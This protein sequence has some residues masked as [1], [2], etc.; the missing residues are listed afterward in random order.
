MKLY[1]N[2]R[3]VI[4]FPRF[5][6]RISSGQQGTVYEYMGKALKILHNDCSLFD[7]DIS[8]KDYEHLKKIDTKR[9]LLPEDSLIDREDNLRAYTLELITKNDY[10]ELFNI[11]KDKFIEELY[12]VR[13]ELKLLSENNVIVH[14]LIME[15]FM[16]DGI[17]RFVDCGR[18]DIEYD[19][20]ENMDE[21][22]IKSIEIEN[23]NKFEDFVID[24]LFFKDK[25]V[26][27][28]IFT[29][30]AEEIK[31]VDCGFVGEYV[32]KTM[33]KH[34]TLNEYVKKKFVSR[35]S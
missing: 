20:L 11:S 9:I 13:K 17:F 35:I 1:L 30:V 31:A 19:N 27:S 34:A 32:E 14:D 24:S 25:I 6:K 33:P 26:P 28:K 15:N 2:G 10:D 12:D 4:I 8:L 5:L 29:E 22:V 21:D 18:F 23:N 3:C 16:Y 7:Y